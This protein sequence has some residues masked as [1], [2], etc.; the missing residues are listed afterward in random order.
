MKVES[1]NFSTNNKRMRF[2]KLWLYISSGMLKQNNLIKRKKLYLKKCF[3]SHGLNRNPETRFFRFV[4][5]L[6]LPFIIY[7][8]LC[9]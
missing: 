2:K 6:N 4:E 5:F 7:H 3:F 8:K 1:T 9:Y